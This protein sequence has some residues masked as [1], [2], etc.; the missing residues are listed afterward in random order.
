MAELTTPNSWGSRVQEFNACHTPAGTPA[1]GQFCSDDEA[2]AEGYRE[3][4]HDSQGAALASARGA[5][6]RESFESSSGVRETMSVVDGAGRY[7][8]RMLVGDEDSVAVPK[9]IWQEWIVR[10]PVVTAHTHPGSSTFSFDDF[11][12][13]CMVN[14]FGRIENPKGPLA[15]TA[16]QVY[17]ED[18]SWYEI[19]F[20]RVFNFPEL[21]QLG[22]AHAE[23]VQLVRGLA[24]A[25]TTRWAQQQAW[26]ANRPPKTWDLMTEEEHIQ[27]A[28]EKAGKLEDL[29]AHFRRRFRDNAKDI[30]TGL[31]A[32]FGGFEYR[33][34]VTD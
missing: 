3:G 20:Q 8:G 26:W 13:H 15:V 10:G 27:H 11:R 24:Q 1:G 32:R 21:Q 18:G 34:H 22:K 7:I 25:A 19:K 6:L 16:M 30:W 12:L 5:M 29:D 9:D 4:Y 2:R 14:A 31:T 17:G 23:K 33:Y 28:A